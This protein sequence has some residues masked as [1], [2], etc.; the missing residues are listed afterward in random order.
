MIIDRV[1]SCGSA[2]SSGGVCWVQGDVPRPRPSR[3]LGLGRGLSRPFGLEQ[4]LSRPSGLGQRLSRPVGRESL[5]FACAK[6]SNQKKAH[7]VLAPSAPAALRVRKAGRNFCKGRPCPLQKRRASMRAALRVVSAGLAA[8][9]WGPESKQQ[10]QQQREL[11]PRQCWRVGECL[12][13]VVRRVPV[14]QRRCLSVV[15]PVRRSAA[16]GAMSA[17]GSVSC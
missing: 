3:P 12:F 10:Q 6:K 16:C 11:I 8:A 2:L 17:R 5:F 14:G 9:V 13:D 4:R 15:R 1:G 7:P